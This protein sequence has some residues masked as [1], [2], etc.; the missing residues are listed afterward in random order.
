VNGDGE[1][2][3]EG[4]NEKGRK[5]KGEESG[6][7]V[8]GGIWPTQKFWCG[9]LYARPLAGFKGAALWRGGGESKE[10]RGT[11]REKR[12]ERR[13]RG[14]EESWNRAV[15]WLR[16]ALGKPTEVTTNTSPTSWVM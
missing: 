16:P 12:A 14:V 8:E 10:G 11:E 4:R 9:T 15:N 3:E 6:D 13:K 5:G 2:G 1:R 7:E